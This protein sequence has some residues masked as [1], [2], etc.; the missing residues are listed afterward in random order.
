MNF[1]RSC[2]SGAPTRNSGSVLR[3][4]WATTASEG[5]WVVAQ[6]EKGQ[7]TLLSWEPQA[8]YEVQRVDPGPAVTASAIFKN[9]NA[10]IRMTVTCVAGIPT[11]VSL[12]L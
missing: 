4:A 9:K 11:P 12:P 3:S 5:G 7:V 1:L 8:P 6:C 2:S 10:K